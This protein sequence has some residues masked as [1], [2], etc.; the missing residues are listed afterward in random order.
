MTSC[1]KFIVHLKDYEYAIGV[2]NPIGYTSEKLKNGLKIHAL[3]EGIPPSLYPLRKFQL[4]G[5][6]ELFEV[7]D[8]DDLSYMM[9]LFVDDEV[10]LYIHD[11]DDKS[12]SLIGE[13]LC[14]DAQAFFDEVDS[15]IYG[16]QY[17]SSSRLRIKDRAFDVGFDAHLS[18]GLSAQANNLG[19]SGCTD[20]VSTDDDRQSNEDDSNGYEPN[21]KDEWHINEA[22]NKHDFEVPAYLR[23]KFFEYNGDGSVTLEVGLMFYDKGKF[24]ESLSDYAV[25][26]GFD[27][28]R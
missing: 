15:I 4:P 24:L 26:N 27:M 7:A 1:K 9:E 16:S 18:D 20:D 28:L 12:K 21:L 8:D 2:V 22:D 3:R 19:E 11:K 14:D 6:H 23:G 13:D 25:F 10:H 17:G 5:L